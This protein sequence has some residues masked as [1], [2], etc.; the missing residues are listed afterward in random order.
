[1]SKWDNWYIKNWTHALKKFKE[2][3]NNNG[4]IVVVD[5]SHFAPM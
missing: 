3:C 4:K 5:P 2:Q 1:M